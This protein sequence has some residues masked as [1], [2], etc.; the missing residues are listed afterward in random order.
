MTSETR[1]QILFLAAVGLFAGITA[2]FFT[3]AWLSGEMAKPDFWS[4]HFEH[5]DST[6]AP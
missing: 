2:S 3:W 4:K 1:A 6:A 5:M